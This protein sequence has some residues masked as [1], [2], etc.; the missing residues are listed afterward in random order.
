MQKH[1]HGLRGVFSLAHTTV[2]FVLVLLLMGCADRQRRNPLDAAAESPLDL[3]D[4]LV[5]A[6]EDGFVRLKWDLTKLTDLEGIRIHRTGGPDGQHVFDLTPST[7]TLI[8]ERVLNGVLYRYSL[9]MLVQDEGEVFVG[10]SRLATPG[11]E[12]SWLADRGSGYVW[13]LSPDGRT[14]LFA[15]GRF[16]SIAAIDVDTRAG[17]CWVSDRRLAALH[18]IDAPGDMVRY[19]RIDAPGDMVRYR[20]ALEGGG[21]LAIDSAGRRGWVADA[22]TF[23]VYSFDLDAI[24]D[25]LQLSEVDGTFR[26]HVDLAVQS[27]FL[28]IADPAGERVLLYDP[29]GQRIAEW[30]GLAGLSR[31]DASAVGNSAWVLAAGGLE[32]LRLEPGRQ[33][34]EFFMPFVDPAV[35]L[36]V[37]DHRGDVWVAGAGDVAA[38]GNDGV[39]ILHWNNVPG[40]RD[41]AIDESNEHVWIA[42]STQL[43]KV[44]LRAASQTHLTG[45]T[46]TVQVIVHA[47]GG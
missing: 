39:P 15:Q 8:D 19:R 6:A 43:W 37:G 27:G 41:V 40:I 17:D 38:Y 26:D 7:E 47:G 28:W 36:D 34:E 29:S 23:E 14:G 4:G 46:E 42:A 31:I 22:R 13:R 18:R 35:A 2:L 30:T 45:F 20:T 10:E 44:S 24:G 16:P 1:R 9:S 3:L 5:V 25:T 33:P 21:D 32:L 12:I 11:P